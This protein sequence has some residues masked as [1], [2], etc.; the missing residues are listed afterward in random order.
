MNDVCTDPISKYAQILK[1]QVDVNFRGHS[2]T[3]WGFNSARNGFYRKASS[4]PA[5]CSSQICSFLGSQGFRLKVS[6]GLGLIHHLY[7]Q[8][9]VPQQP[10]SVNFT[11]DIWSQVARLCLLPFQVNSSPT[12]FLSHLP[13]SPSSHTTLISNK[14]PSVPQTCFPPHPFRPLL[15][16]ECLFPT[17]DTFMV[18]AGFCGAFSP[19]PPHPHSLSHFDFSTP[20]AVPKLSL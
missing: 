7:I 8:L 13:P 4:H 20:H 2:S 12:Y 3:H 10:K 18:M 11:E 19:H 1:F 5:S 15:C 16:L 9:F 17:S 6:P 14:L